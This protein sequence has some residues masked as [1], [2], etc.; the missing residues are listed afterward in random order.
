MS[1]RLDARDGRRPRHVHVTCPGASR[2]TGQNCHSHAESANAIIGTLG[3][4]VQERSADG[5]REVTSTDASAPP[6]AAGNVQLDSYSEPDPPT[7]ATTAQSAPYSDPNRT[8]SPQ[9]S[10]WTRTANPAGPRSP[11]PS[12]RTRTANPTRPH[13]PETS[14]RTDTATP[15]RP[16][17]SIR[18]HGRPART[19]RAA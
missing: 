14:S 2:L 19:N 18:T 1:S 11:Q 13:S 12:N 4:R 17:R 15:A 9:P 5:V 16:R 6:R 3:V 8:R 7:L 10:N